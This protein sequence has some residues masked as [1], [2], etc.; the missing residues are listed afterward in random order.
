ML[1][2]L[3]AKSEV[4]S[5]INKFE[6]MS[7]VDVKSQCV[8]VSADKAQSGSLSPNMALKNVVAEIKDKNNK[9]K[10]IIFYQSENGFYDLE[11]NRIILSKLEKGSILKE[12]VIYLKNLEVKQMEMK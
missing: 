7:C 2:A 11:T 12:T 3:T 9:D 4:E 8:F 1:L 5:H 6:L 10:I